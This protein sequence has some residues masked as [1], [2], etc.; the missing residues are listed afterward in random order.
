MLQPQTKLEQTRLI[1]KKLV[2]YG[3]AEKIQDDKVVQIEKDRN[4]LLQMF[5]D[6]MELKEITVSDCFRLGNE[7]PQRSRPLVFFY[8]PL[9]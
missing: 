9:P 7:Q 4:S 3:L 5:R 2:I 8:I 6:R 1:G